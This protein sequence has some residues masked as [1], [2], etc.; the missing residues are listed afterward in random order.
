ML[1]DGER[2]LMPVTLMDAQAR[3][4][5]AHLAAKYGRSSKGDS[6]MITDGLGNPG[7]LRPGYVFSS[8]HT[9]AD[10][11]RAAY[12]ERS[13]RMETAWQR[14]G[15][16]QQDEKRDAPRTLDELRAAADAAYAD[17]SKRLA[18]AW[19]RRDA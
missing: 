11:A 2:F 18:N 16:Q 7:G 15:D 5:A 13:R 12:D 17:R 9:S 6:S 4:V 14:K 3:D 19:R 10:A 1:M 8:D